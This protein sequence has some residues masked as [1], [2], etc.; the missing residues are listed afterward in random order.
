VLLEHGLKVTAVDTGEMDE[1]LSKNKNFRYINNN[2]SELDLGEEKYD[3]IT[4]D[5]SWNALRTAR[6]VNKASLYLK[7]GGTAIVTVKLMSDKIWRSVKDVMK[8]YE[9]EFEI[10]RAKQ[11]FHNREEITLLMTKGRK[12]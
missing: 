12:N 7:E 5:I 4:S 11:L 8:I 6:M 3:L 1:R 9:E 2:A 10:I